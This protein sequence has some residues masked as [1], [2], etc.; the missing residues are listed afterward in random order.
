MN[1]PCSPACLFFCSLDFLLRLEPVLELGAGF[2]TSLNVE[3]IGSWPN[4]FFQG[5]V[6]S[7]GDT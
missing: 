7:L 2:I 3:F 5:K 6:F 1:L 4:S